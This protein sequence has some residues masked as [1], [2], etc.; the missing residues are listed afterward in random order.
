[1]TDIARS[2]TP[3]E[4]W[5]KVAEFPNYEI[6]D[7]GNAWSIPR[8]RCR[9]GLLNPWLNDQGYLC[10]TLY[11]DGRLYKRKVHI[12]VAVAFLGPRP[13]GQEVLHGPNGKLDNRASEL[14]YG[15]HWQNNMDKFRD[16]TQPLGEGHPLATLSAKLV[17]ECRELHAGGASVNGLA[18]RYGVGLGALR[19]AIKGRTWRHVETAPV[20]L[21]VPRGQRHK[22]ARL[23][24]VIVIEC[25]RRSLE[26]ERVAALAREFGVSA[27]AMRNAITGRTWKHATPDIQVV[28]S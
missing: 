12:L 20:T 7:H 6:S 3:G 27:P 28:N 24:E 21:G 17:A 16:G 5:L 18:E 13:E 25:R 2:G 9:G 4:V 26:G 23:S 10:V 8:F 1:M 15:T 14:R 19:D 22:D 11:R